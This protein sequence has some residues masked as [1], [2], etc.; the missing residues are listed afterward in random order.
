MRPRSK[1]IGAITALLSIFLS[2]FVASVS[3]TQATALNGTISSISQSI[4]SD[5]TSPFDSASGE[6]LDTSSSN[7][8]VRTHDS[9]D[10]RWDYVVSGSGN[11]TFSST[12]TNALWNNSSTGSCAEGLNAISANKRT[13][14]C[15]LS[16][17]STGSGSYTV[18]ATADGN[19]ANNSSITGFVSSGSTAS[20]PL[21]LSVSATPKLNISTTDLFVNVSN[22]PGSFSTVSGYNYDVPVAMW[23]SVAGTLDGFAGVKGTEALSSPI[24]FKALTQQPNALLVGCSSGPAGGTRPMYP[25]G[26]GGNGSSNLNSV[27]NSGT[28]S[29]TQASAGAPV[30]VSVSG[31]DTS[32][33]SYP[34]MSANNVS[35]VSGGKAYVAVGYVRLWIPKSASTPNALTT[36]RTQIMDFDPNSVSGT[37]N[38][39]SLFATNQPGT[40]GTCVTGINQ[41][42]SVS[43]VNRVQQNITAGVNLFSLTGG[44]LPGASRE[45]DLTSQVTP[46][47]KFT[48]QSLASVPTG[49]DVMSNVTICMKWD[50]SYGVIDTSRNVAY[51]SGGL[52]VTIEYG[53]T[54]YTTLTEYQSNSCGIVGNPSSNWYSSVSAAG[55]SNAVTAV[56]MTIN[57]SLAA[58]T[59]FSMNVPLVAGFDLTPGVVQGFFATVSSQELSGVNISF[60][61]TT[62]IGTGGNRVTWLESR[63]TIYTSWDVSG[64]SAPATRTIT[65]SPTLVTGPIARSLQAVVTLPSSC[66]S[67]VPGSSSIVPTSIIPANYGP[68]GISCTADDVSSEV[69]TFS[70]GDV[71]LSPSPVTLRVNVDSKIPTPSTVSVLASV[72]STSDP[73]AVSSHNSSSALQ[74]SS[75]AGFSVSKTADT[76]RVREGVPFNYTISWSNTS[77]TLSGSVNIVDVLPFSGDGRGSTGFS[78]LT[79]NAVSSSSATFEYSTISAESALALAAE[80]PDGNDS[81]FAW[82]TIPPTQPTAVRIS[83]SNL[84]TQSSGSATLNVTANGVV[85]GGSLVNDTYAAASFLATPLLGAASLAIPTLGTSSISV[86]KT[87]TLSE[88]S[89]AG[90]RLSW[91]IHVT[92][93]GQESLSGITVTESGFNGSGPVPTI[94]CP[95]LVLAAEESMDC[96]TSR[97]IVSQSDMDNLSSI[98]NTVAASALPPIGS[99]ISSETS[100][101]VT[102][103][104][105]SNSLTLLQ[106]PSTSNVTA[107]GTLVTYTF[108][109]TNTGTQTLSG[110]RLDSGTVDGS[111]ITSSPVCLATSL[112]PGTSTSCTLNYTVTQADL[113]TKNSLN[114]SKTA[115]GSAPGLNVVT[116][117]TSTSSVGITTSPSLSL[118]KS[119]NISSFSGAGTPLVYTFEVVNTGNVTL[120]N[121]EILE[122]D[123]TGLNPLSPISCA[124]QVLTPGQHVLCTADYTT[125]QGDL[126]AGSILNSASASATFGGVTISSATST[127]NTPGTQRIT[128]ITISTTSDI[129]EVRWA[130]DQVEFTFTVT[131]SGNLTLHG[132]SV[133]INNFDANSS[134]PTI[135]C[136]DTAL[137]PLGSMQC[138]VSFTAAQADIDELSEITLISSVE[139]LSPSNSQVA[140][141]S[142]PLVIEVNPVAHLD[143]SVIPSTG[144][145]IQAGQQITFD[146]QILNS[147]AYTMSNLSTSFIFSGTFQPSSL[148][149]PATV[150]SPNEAMHCTVNYVTAQEDIDNLNALDL[151]VNA[152]GIYGN[153]EVYDSTLSRDTNNSTTVEL[154]PTNKVS[155]AKFASISRVLTA[156]KTFTYSFLATNL[157]TQTLRNVTVT[158]VAF[159]GRGEPVE[160]NCPVVATLAPGASITCTGNYT[161]VSADLQLSEIS[162]TAIASSSNSGG[163][164]SRNAIAKVSVVNASESENSNS[165]TARLA[166]TGN[167]PE[168]IFGLALL[169]I[170]SGVGSVAF[171]RFTS[172]RQ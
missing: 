26:S 163:I 115:I 33:N 140:A 138:T 172:N 127:V 93:T 133:I 59:N 23:A 134:L 170:F 161:T 150:L 142:N 3:W 114:L 2:A 159:T 47:T 15:T 51:Q 152:T 54:D 102:P 168:N 28:W 86:S 7:R 92:N 35:I 60:D 166:R 16:N 80:H 118:T 157:G 89:A 135:A 91:V 165:N 129:D 20:A 19:A 82:T 110:L 87:P 61:P 5:G 143:I 31:A 13:L 21:A 55:G 48:A 137:A 148:I 50:P 45:F 8:V 113:D 43:V 125:V 44:T 106:N 131:N 74:V 72:S 32:L 1:K 160:V 69:L 128:G 65:V 103:I 153:N 100:T 126:D 119:A 57:G 14:T 162:N 83:I 67:Y 56:R 139:A 12:L 105:G 63:V 88:I 27:R 132:V 124:G 70:F 109:L 112:A 155:L 104:S 84:A 117:N 171:V 52:G 169:M 136:P 30:A 29:C 64:T 11:I 121:L 68:D 6:G 53:T 62:G 96:T 107:A 97:Y 39:Q 98:S 108:V 66:F 79:L 38:Y 85:A 99:R 167:N 111:G 49:N 37:S 22:G 120:S 77:T 40:A 123:F 158:E 76:G 46:G 36:L 90:Q 17:L 9:F 146:V 145:A 75:V 95:R 73:L 151:E 42:C 81:R 154:Q 141:S 4:V 24:T 116:S 71:N 18:R 10:I 144:V 94:S 149:C 78:S 25:N 130:G 41:N 101:A 156:S 58:G 122:G 147:G 164:Q 34:T